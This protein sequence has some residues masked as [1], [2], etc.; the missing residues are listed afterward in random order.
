MKTNINLM[1][2]HGQYKISIDDKVDGTGV[3]YLQLAGIAPEQ[4]NRLSQIAMLSSLL[5]SLLEDY[6]ATEVRAKKHE[7]EIDSQRAEL[8]ELRIEREAL[9]RLLERYGALPD[10]MVLD[11]VAWL[12]NKSHTTSSDFYWEDSSGTTITPMSEPV[13]EEHLFAGMDADISK[14]IKKEVDKIEV[15]FQDDLS[16]DDFLD[17][18]YASLGDSEKLAAMHEL[19]VQYNLNDGSIYNRIALIL[20][21]DAARFAIMKDSR[22]DERNE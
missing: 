1:T 9:V 8:Y 11:K 5:L 10:D 7:D 18:G 6:P 19:L 2:E 16:D 21:K 4:V 13:P 20:R 15:I 3:K 22:G 12:I 17:L 14:I